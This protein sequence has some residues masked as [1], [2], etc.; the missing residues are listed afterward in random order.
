MT[1]LRKHMLAPSRLFC[2][3]QRAER[4]AV[5]MALGTISCRKVQ[6]GSIRRRKVA[7]FRRATK[8]MSGNRPLYY[9][10]NALMRFLYANLW[11]DKPSSAPNY[12]YC[13][14]MRHLNIPCW[15]LRIFDDSE[16]LGSMQNEPISPHVT[17]PPNH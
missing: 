12:R 14:T 1:H 17:S 8:H 2:A 9:R 11:K 7:I 6:I 16:K 10:L 3:Q 15:V 4:Q 5:S 13:H